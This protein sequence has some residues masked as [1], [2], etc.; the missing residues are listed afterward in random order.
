MIVGEWRA[1]ERS[2]VS[3]PT[4]SGVGDSVA[5]LDCALTNVVTDAGQVRRY[6]AAARK[7]VR[8]KGTLIP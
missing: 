1:A 6:A 2:P 4:L 8:L 5:L 7:R 3:R